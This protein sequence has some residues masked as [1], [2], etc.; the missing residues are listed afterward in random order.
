MADEFYG[1]TYHCPMCNMTWTFDN[2]IDASIFAA[3]H[4]NLHM[5][6]RAHWNRRLSR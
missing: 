3:D 4:G 1:A 5:I 2:D 6:E